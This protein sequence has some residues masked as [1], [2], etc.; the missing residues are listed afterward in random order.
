[1]THNDNHTFNCFKNL[2]QIE[3]I[4]KTNRKKIYK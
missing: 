4:I 1:M 2:F 3:K